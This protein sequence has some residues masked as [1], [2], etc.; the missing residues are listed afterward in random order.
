MAGK[1]LLANEATVTDV[2]V[3]GGIGPLAGTFLGATWA[4]VR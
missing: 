4:I 2:L 1:V 3:F